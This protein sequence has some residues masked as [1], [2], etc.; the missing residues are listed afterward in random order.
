MRWPTLFDKLPWNRI[1]SVKI[2]RLCRPSWDQRLNIPWNKEQKSLPFVMYERRSWGW[3]RMHRHQLAH[4]V[5]VFC[6]QNP[7]PP[8]S[9]EARMAGS[10]T[11]ALSTFSNFSFPLNSASQNLSVRVF[12]L[13]NPPLSRNERSNYPEVLPGCR[14]ILSP[15]ADEFIEMMWSQDGG[16]SGQILKVIHDDSNKQVQHLVNKSTRS[17]K[18][19]I[20][21]K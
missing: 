3:I 10:A 8:A 16:V 18:L 7:S 6:L 15:H 11:P 14:V 1:K 17:F 20:Q 2:C 9:E 5:E 19:L 13:T 4:C 12:F 21:F